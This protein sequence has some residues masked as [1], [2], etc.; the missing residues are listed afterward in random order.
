MPVGWRVKLA[1]G[2]VMKPVEAHFVLVF[3]TVVALYTV[4][5]L[6]GPC[7]EGAAVGDSP[8][9]CDAG[10]SPKPGDEPVGAEPA[11]WDSVSEP[12]LTDPMG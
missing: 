12:S 1:E 2:F 8:E 7:M 9:P 3:L 4:W 5:G 10:D 11:V 6:N